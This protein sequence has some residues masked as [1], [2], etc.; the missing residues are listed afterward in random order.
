MTA[1]L[2][3]ELGSGRELKA[4]GVRGVLVE[5]LE[6]AGFA[7]VLLRLGFVAWLG[8]EGVVDRGVGEDVG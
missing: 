5:R 3:I 1:G 8:V 6:L 2:F 7:L 4:S